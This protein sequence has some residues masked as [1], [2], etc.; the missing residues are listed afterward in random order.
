VNGTALNL[1]FVPL[2]DAAPL[3][4]AADMGFAL[5]EG[6]SLN[7]IAA[8]SWAG[9][10]DLLADGAVDAAHML[11]VLPVALALGLGGRAAHF[12]V[13]SVLSVNGEVFG[14][15]KALAAKMSPAPADAFAMG[16]A[17]LNA[18]GKELRIGVP[19][20]FSMHALLVRYWLDGLKRDLPAGLSIETLPPS[21]M[22]AALEAGAIDAMMLGEPWGSLAVERGQAD[23]ILTGGQIWGFAPEKVLAVR[24][25]WAD[26]DPLRAGALVRAIWRAGRW[27]AAPANRTTASEILARSGHI[28]ATSD[29]IDRLLAGQIGLIG[30]AA[31]LPA[32][33]EFHAGAATFPWRSQAGWIADRLARLH[34]LNRDTAIIK[35]KAI[36]RTD[37]HR[38][39]L[40]STGADLPGASERV[41]GAVDHPTA[42]AS[43]RGELIL[44]PDS[45]FDGQVFDPRQTS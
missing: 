14:V 27:L 24:R 18:A 25:R 10:R 28:E 33:V 1:G 43:R 8:P 3:I 26:E 36:F 39:F 7:L 13:L 40:A 45:F 16:H 29:L 22:G 42:V 44:R 35:A 20:P 32:L 41:E 38:Q 6:L 34:G 19:F 5:E 15:S 11:S 30:G 21:Q 2:L 37:L 12:D 31:Q 9:L 17:L 4:I 23:L